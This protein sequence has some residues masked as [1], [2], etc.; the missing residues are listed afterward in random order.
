MILVTNAAGQLCNRLVLLSHA[1]AT[2][3]ESKQKVI[4]LVAK[5]IKKDIILQGVSL[6]VYNRDT[7]WIFNYYEKIMGIIFRGGAEVGTKIR[8]VV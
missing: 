8:L 2:G 4:H 5:D 7:K 3:L 6:S 1:Y